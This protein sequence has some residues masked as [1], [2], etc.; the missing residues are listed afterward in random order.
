MYSL[1]VLFS[2]LIALITSPL[3]GITFQTCSVTAFILYFIFTNLALTK[4][5]SKLKPQWILVACLIGC[6]IF[7]IPIRVV[8]FSETLLS[9]PDFLF[10][11]FGIFMGYLFYISGKYVKSG[12]VVTSLLCCTFLY[13]KGYNLWLHKLNYG[14]FSG[15]VQ[16]KAEMPEFYFTDKNGN[17]I[18]NQDFAGKY[19]VLDF[20]TT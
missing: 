7:Q 14:T 18:T 4:Q 15:I 16:Y 12:I 8:N 17:T 6:S 5:G 11:L 3:R 19:T 13:F 20:W 2:L 9:L 10:H 1:I